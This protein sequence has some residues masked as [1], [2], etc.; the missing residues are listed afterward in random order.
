MDKYQGNSNDLVV[1][2]KLLVEKG[3]LVDNQKQQGFTALMILANK[4]DYNTVK[5]LIEQCG[6]DKTITFNTLVIWL[7]SYQNFTAYNF[8]VKNKNIVLAKYLQIYAPDHS[9]RGVKNNFKDLESN[10]NFELFYANKKKRKLL[11]NV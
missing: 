4:N 3:D 11:L 5:F 6:A 8:A 1:W 7:K 9:V 2:I 10:Y